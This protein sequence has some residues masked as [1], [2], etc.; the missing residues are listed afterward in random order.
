MIKKKFGKQDMKVVVPRAERSI[1][2]RKSIPHRKLRV[3]CPR[4]SLFVYFQVAYS[5]I[6][7]HIPGK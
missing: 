3:P 6:L 1:C 5:C 4:S 2:L 7:R